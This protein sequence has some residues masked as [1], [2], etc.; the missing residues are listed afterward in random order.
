MDG[1]PEI[2][3]NPSTPLESHASTTGAQPAPTEVKIRTMRSDL[4][5]LAASG[6]G[7]PKFQNVK[8]TGLS[9]EKKTD[10]TA[11]HKSDAL[12]AIIITVAAI[13]VLCVLGYFG[14][15]ILTTGSL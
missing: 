12:T 4:A 7:M 8:I 6:G 14:Y 5:G 11:E 3:R 1:L 13:V 2:N 9:V 10:V 15:K